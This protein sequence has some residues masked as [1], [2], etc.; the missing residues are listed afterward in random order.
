MG[1]AA[2]PEI[3]D[4]TFHDLE[5]KILAK[6]GTK[7][8]LWRRF[9]DDIFMIYNGTE[10]ELENFL[11][12]INNMHQTYKFTMESSKNKVTYL[13]L[14]IFKGH[15]HSQT[16]ILDIRTQSYKANRYIPISAPTVMSS[17]GHIQGFLSKVNFCATFVHAVTKRTSTEKSSFSQKNCCLEATQRQNYR[18]SQHISNSLIE[19]RYWKEKAERQTNMTD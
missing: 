10:T 15:R 17:A 4:I 5:R 16:G 13:D 14:E 8:D 11:K 2:S 6:Y 7:I 19:H 9:R 12:E 3:A 18:S 1:S